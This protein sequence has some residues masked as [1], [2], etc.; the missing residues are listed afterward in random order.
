M[1]KGIDHIGI[2]VRD[3]TSALPLFQEGMGLKLLGIE[4]IAEDNVKVASL[5]IGE[6]RIELIEPIK[7]GTPVFRFLEKRGEG[8]HH[9]ALRVEDAKE[10]IGRLKEAGLEPVEGRS[11]TGAMGL[12]VAFIHP[13]SCHGVLM[14]VCEE[15]KPRGKRED[16]HL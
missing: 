9:I 7:E 16:G 13:K 12:V 5:A 4:V 3:I 8:V 11:Q 2:V 10:A 6:S 14:E 15:L 1:F